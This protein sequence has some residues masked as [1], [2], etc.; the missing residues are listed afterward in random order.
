MY[1]CMLGVGPCTSRCCVHSVPKSS[2]PCSPLHFTTY[3]L[4]WLTQFC[5]ATVAIHRVYSH[6]PGFT[7]AGAFLLG[8]LGISGLRPTQVSLVRCV[9]SR[10]SGRR[11]CV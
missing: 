7:G 8:L 6:V 11:K 4:T 10:G 3:L 9:T 1:F 5:R 2:R